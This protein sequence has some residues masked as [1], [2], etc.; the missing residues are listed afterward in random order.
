MCLGT[1]ALLLGLTGCEDRPADAPASMTGNPGVEDQTPQA[2]PADA[3]VEDPPQAAEP[4]PAA[5]P[6]P[7]ADTQ[8][9]TP[10]PPPANPLGG[11]ELCHADL[12]KGFVASKHYA[13]KVGCIKCHGPSDGHIRDENNEVLPDRL[14]VRKDID[15]FCGECHECERDTHKDLVVASQ[16]KP[17]CTNCHDAHSLVSKE[18]PKP[19]STPTAARSCLLRQ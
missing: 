13:E 2:Q 8:P 15:E 1:L 18:Q 9:G 14:F 17:V 12:E 7:S 6:P 16:P 10:A 11:C 5:D 4:A 19:R 3:P